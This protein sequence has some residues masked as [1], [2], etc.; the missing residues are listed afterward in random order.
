MQYFCKQYFSHFL[1]TYH[2]QWTRSREHLHWMCFYSIRVTVCKLYF[3]H[4]NYWY[5]IWKC[6]RFQQNTHIITH[7]V[8]LILKLW[9]IQQKRN[10]IA[11]IYRLGEA[12]LLLIILSQQDFSNLFQLNADLR[13]K[14]T[15]T[16]TSSLYGLPS[17][18]S[19]NSSS[20]SLSLSKERHGFELF[21]SHKSQT[22]TWACSLYTYFHFLFVLY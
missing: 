18:F 2:K 21:S 3:L 20:P 10:V 16:D 19:D 6:G 13:C 11:N 5:F 17:G 22:V 15:G 14:N 12:H 7:Y 1:V 4:Q 9:M 8:T